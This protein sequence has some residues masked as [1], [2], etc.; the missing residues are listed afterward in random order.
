MGG[1]LTRSGRVESCG[2]ESRDICSR[3]HGVSVGGSKVLKSPNQ[4]SWTRSSTYSVVYRHARNA[5]LP[6]S[7]HLRHCGWKTVMTPVFVT[8]LGL[9]ENHTSLSTAI[10]ASGT[11]ATGPKTPYRARPGGSPTS[12]TVS[13]LPPNKVAMQPPPSGNH[14]PRRG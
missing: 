6:S 3:I 8:I 14:K 5:C 13:R 9:D 2:A 4:R 11:E 10:P 1:V 7:P 12:L